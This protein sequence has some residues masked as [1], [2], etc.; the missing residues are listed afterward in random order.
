MEIIL[1]NEI[2]KKLETIAIEEN[3]SIDEL[4]N[5]IIEDFF[6]GGCVHE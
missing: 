6:I 2:F 3:K 1:E 5:D 4:V